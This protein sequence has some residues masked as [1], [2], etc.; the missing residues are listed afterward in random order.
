MCDMLYL[1]NTSNL[2]K[3]GDV[4]YRVCIFSIAILQCS[5]V[6]KNSYSIFFIRLG[7]IANTK[8]IARST[9]KRTIAHHW[10]LP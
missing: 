8:N 9:K 7:I 4:W 3:F 10:Y 2:L 6:K 1:M 5:Y